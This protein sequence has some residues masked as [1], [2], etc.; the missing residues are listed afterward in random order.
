MDGLCVYV[1]WEKEERR[2]VTNELSRVMLCRIVGVKE[3]NLKSQCHQE[4]EGWYEVER[5]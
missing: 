4:V 2:I 5:E 1:W 3:G